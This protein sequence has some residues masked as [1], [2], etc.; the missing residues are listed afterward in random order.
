M[1]VQ[2]MQ[3]THQKLKCSSDHICRTSLI[4]LTSLMHPQAKKLSKHKI[5]ARDA[6]YVQALDTGL[7]WQVVRHDVISSIE[8]LPL[9]LQEAGNLVQSA[10]QAEHVLQ[11]LM[12]LKRRLSLVRTYDPDTFDFEALLIFMFSWFVIISFM[13]PYVYCY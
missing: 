2:C 13:S 11:A 7:T 5:G 1:R 9:L 10:C 12:K 4:G 8:G 3:Y 6:A